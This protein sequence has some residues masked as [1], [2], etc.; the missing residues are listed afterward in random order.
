MEHAET[1][2]RGQLARIFRFGR[3]HKK[4]SVGVSEWIFPPVVK[5][6]G[7]TTACLSN[8]FHLGN[9]EQGWIAIGA[10][11]YFATVEYFRVLVRVQFRIYT[12]VETFPHGQGCLAYVDVAA[13]ARRER[14]APADGLRI[15]STR[16]SLNGVDILQHKPDLRHITCLAV[17]GFQRR[18]CSVL[19]TVNRATVE[20]ITLCLT[21]LLFLF[22]AG[23]YSARPS[24]HCLIDHGLYRCDLTRPYCRR[25]ENESTA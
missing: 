12:T 4:C 9:W 18:Y 5:I 14:T 8:C 22:M 10:E 7:P 21:R 2:R 11:P 13:I 3:C 23:N 24:V 20:D 19:L 1:Y 6:P 16:Y 17:V 15:N 25:R